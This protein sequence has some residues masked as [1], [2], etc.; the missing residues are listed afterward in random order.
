MTLMGLTPPRHGRTQAGPFFRIHQTFGDG[1]YFLILQ[2]HMGA[3]HADK[4]FRPEHPYMPRFHHS[5]VLIQQAP[6]LLQLTMLRGQVFHRCAQHGRKCRM[7][8]DP[9]EQ[10]LLFIGMVLRGGQ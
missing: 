9:G 4:R 3:I 8:Q 5:Q 2:G 7:L 1:K 6:L 10:I